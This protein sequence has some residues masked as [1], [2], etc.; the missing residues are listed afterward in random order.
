[1]LI[2]AKE[3]GFV[4]DASARALARRRSQIIGLVLTRSPDHIA[5]DAFL[6]QILDGLVEAV[7]QHGMR[8]LLEIVD[9]LHHNE[10]YLELAQTKRIDGIILSGPRFDDEALQVLDES[11]FPTVL[12]GQL[13]G[14][15]FHSVDVDNRG[16]AQMAV[17]HLLHQN[18]RKIACITNAPQ[19]YTAAMERLHGYRLALEAF[20]RDYD[21]NL[22]RFGD[23]DMDSGY[24]QM[25]SIL[26][27]GELPDSVFIAS[28]VVAFG[29]MRSI[30]EHGLR[31]PEDIAI[32]GFDD[33]PMSRFV[34]PPLTTVHLP[35]MDLAQKSIGLLLQLIQGVKPPQNQLF[36]D[37]YLVIRDS[38][39]ADSRS[40][41][42]EN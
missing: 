17:T 40:K 37:S 29:A 15:S 5:S 4:P 14:S 18:Y 3:L 7:R 13:P 30:Q 31:I 8:L 26:E 10:I 27:N 32:V 22:V 42:Q 6:T 19:T 1:V 25:Q 9:D 38:C 24:T 35:A 39:G 12:M 11:G 34:T 2:A 21:P 16:A 20:G 41:S 28:D 33:V 23:F 36:V